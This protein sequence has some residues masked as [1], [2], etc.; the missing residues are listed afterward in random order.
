MN[1]SCDSVDVLTPEKRR[2][3]MSAIKNRDTQPEIAVKSMQYKLG[4]R[5]SLCSDKLPGKPDIVLKKR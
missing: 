5:F 4:R 3:N 1:S 2:K